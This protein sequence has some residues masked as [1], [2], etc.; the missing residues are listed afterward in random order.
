MRKLRAFGLRL[1]AFSAAAVPTTT[2][3]PNSNPTS[4][5]IPT[6]VSAPG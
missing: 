4:R 2:S 1:R 3:P 5:S 6:P